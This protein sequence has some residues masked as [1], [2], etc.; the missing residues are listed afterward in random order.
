MY[1]P[2]YTLGS[3]PYPILGFVDDYGSNN[4]SSL[5]VSNITCPVANSLTYTYQ[6][7]YCD[8]KTS[9]S[10]TDSG[11]SGFSD[12]PVISCINSKC[13][14]KYFK[15]L[16]HI[17]HTVGPVPCHLQFASPSFGVSFSRSSGF[18]TV[19]QVGVCINFTYGHVCAAGITDDVALL[20]CNAKGTKNYFTILISIILDRGWL[21]QR[22]CI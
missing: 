3:R 4:Q 13:M 15:A 7:N 12:E 20:F 22:H 10:D 6:F 8:S 19:F 21:C 11:C 18:V 14:N 2:Q 9:V 5:L 1:Y 16:F 17:I